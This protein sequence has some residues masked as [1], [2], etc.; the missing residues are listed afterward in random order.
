MILYAENPQMVMATIE[1]S[2]QTLIRPTERVEKVVLAIE[3]IFPS[4]VMDIRGDRIEAYGGIKSLGTLHKLLRDQQILD[5]SRLVMLNGQ[6]G[7]SIQFRLNKQAAFMG[8]INFP[9]E[10]E[11]LGSIHV[12]ITGDDLVIDWLAPRTENGIPVQ[13]I[14]APEDEKLETRDRRRDIE[15]ERSLTDSEEEDV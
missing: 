6:V 7:E 14:D 9:L 8:R 10:E 4:L 13:E 5:T 12:Q 2:V 3:N 15:D 1:V 11:P